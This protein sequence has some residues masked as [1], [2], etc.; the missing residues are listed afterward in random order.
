M[1]HGSAILLIS[2]QSVN[3]TD[4]APVLDRL[5]L[6]S[7]TRED[8]WLYQQQLSLVFEG[9]DQD[10]R[11]LTDI[12]E[13]RS[14]VLALSRLWPYWAYFLSY[15]STDLAIW[16]ACTCG[17]RFLGHGAIELDVSRLEK[18]MAAGYD[19]MNALWDRHGFPESELEIQSDAFA[20]KI[21]AFS[22]E[23]N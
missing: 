10:P 11:E 23:Q 8:C 17:S 1:S 3:E 15:E 2:R 22:G 6:L 5:K 21:I 20:Q 14:Y 16:L 9:W 12:G 19:G 7:A 13:V 4:T 18:A